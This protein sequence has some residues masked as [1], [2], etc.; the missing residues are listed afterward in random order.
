MYQVSARPKGPASCWSMKKVTPASLA[1]GPSSSAGMRRLTAD[2]MNANSGPVKKDKVRAAAECE[3]NKSPSAALARGPNQ[4]AI[5]ID[6][7]PAVVRSISLRVFLLMFRLI[8]VRLRGKRRNS[9][10][11][12]PCLQSR[13][14]LHSRYFIVSATFCRRRSKL[15]TLQISVVGWERLKARPA[16]TRLF[17]GSCCTRRESMKRVRECDTSAGL[18][19]RNCSTPDTL[20]SEAASTPMPP[21]LLAVILRSR[22]DRTSAVF[23]RI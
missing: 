12:R 10:P 5:A 4:E 2:S 15:T 20:I 11:L 22:F 14:G 19:V 17:R 9:E 8:L 3:D 16:D 7:A 6:P 1:P 21:E 18:R 23:Y 13:T